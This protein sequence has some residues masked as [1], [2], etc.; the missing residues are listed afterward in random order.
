LSP[1]SKPSLDRLRTTRAEPAMRPPSLAP[2]L[3]G[4]PAAMAVGGP[5][6]EAVDAAGDTD[7]EHD[8]NRDPDGSHDRCPRLQLVAAAP[9]PR[10]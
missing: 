9:T 2:E 10:P 7:D 5:G 8:Q 3:G 1:L 6:H 4:G